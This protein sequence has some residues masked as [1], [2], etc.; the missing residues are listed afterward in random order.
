MLLPLG[1]PPFDD[2]EEAAQLWAKYMAHGYT[3][4]QAHVFLRMVADTDA[5]LAR[6]KEI[7]GETDER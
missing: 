7:A 3:V 5:V 4:Q 6:A 1:E 2:V